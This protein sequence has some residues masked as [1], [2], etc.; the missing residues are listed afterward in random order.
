MVSLALLVRELLEVVTD[1]D[2]ISVIKNI[3]SKL[4]IEFSSL[5]TLND[6]ISDQIK[7]ESD[8]IYL[9]SKYSRIHDSVNISL[10]EM[11]GIMQMHMPS[12]F[13]GRKVTKELSEAIMLS[14]QNYLKLK[15]E[16]L[17]WDNLCRTL[18][19]IQRM[20]FNRDRKLEIISNNYRKEM[21]FDESN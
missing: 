9:I 1:R 4:D 7:L 20:I 8:I 17:K 13:G 10:E 18:Q 16:V 15:R 12:E 14:D 3:A 6:L 21:K 2:D 11:R 5:S 19:T